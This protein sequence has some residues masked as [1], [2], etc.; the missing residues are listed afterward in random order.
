MLAIADVIR[1]EVPGSIVPWARS[2]GGRGTPR[3][4]PKKQRDFMATIRQ[5]GAD[6]RPGNGLIDGPIELK[7]LAVWPW[8]QSISRRKRD[9]PG[10]NLKRSVPDAD[11]ISKIVKDSLNCVLWTDD[12]RICDLHVFKRFGDRPGLTVEVRAL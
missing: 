5:F 2:G 11:N 1:F 4:T 7:I 8:P 9:L 3:F 10:A 12:A 6:A